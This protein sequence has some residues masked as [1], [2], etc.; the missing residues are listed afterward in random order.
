MLSEEGGNTEANVAGTGYSD[1]KIIKISHN[2]N[3][4]S[5]LRSRAIACAQSEIYTRV[6]RYN[7][8]LDYANKKCFF[9]EKEGEDSLNLPRETWRTEGEGD[10]E[11]GA[12]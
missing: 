9:L 5:T 12:Q 7:F 10:L 3:V 8:F 6:Q 1:F 4:Y 2:C 11:E